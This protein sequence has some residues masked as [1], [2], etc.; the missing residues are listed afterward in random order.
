MQHPNPTAS[1]ETFTIVKNDTVHDIDEPLR[2]RMASG[3]E[4]AL[5]ELMDRHMR[6]IHGTAYHMLGDN[7]Q[8]EDVTQMV[9]LKLWQIAPTW[10]P[11]RA[12]L[13][14]YLYRITHHRCLDILR[15]S[16]ESL[17]GELPDMA[18]E[19]PTAFNNI[20]QAEQAERVQYALQ[21]L[22]D[23]QRAALTLFYFEHQSLKM[24]ANILNV[25]PAAFESLLRRGRKSLK[26]L[27]TPET[28]RASNIVEPLT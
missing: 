13:L 27:L 7:M 12:T 3:D 5:G 6:K 16:K 18:D 9:F 24:A 19:R 28:P 1:G 17:P 25:S 23:R 22:P 20:V 21:Q 8:A 15:K 4:R 14:T 11:G 26:S 10:E 2:L